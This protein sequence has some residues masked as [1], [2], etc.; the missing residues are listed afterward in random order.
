MSTKWIFLAVSIVVLLGTFGLA[1]PLQIINADFSAIAITCQQGYSYQSFGGDCNSIPPQQDFNGTP[2][3]GWTFGFI[4]G[5]GLTGPNTDFNPPDFTGLPF[6]QAAF[7]QD[8]AS[9][10]SQDIP[11]FSAGTNYVLSFYVGSRYFNDGFDGNQTVEALID[12]TLIGTWPLVSFT[13]FELENVPFT[14][15]TDGVHRLTFMGTVFGDHTAFVSGVSINEVPEPATLTLTLA[16]I[17]GAI[18]QIR[19]QTN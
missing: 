1:A 5:N 19:R 13:P 9:S 15:S 7:L 12:D 6:T 4:S 16:G 17:L 3:F 14:V 18:R 11:G 10:V 2:G 8:G